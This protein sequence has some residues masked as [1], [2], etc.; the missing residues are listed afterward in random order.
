MGRLSAAQHASI[1][2]ALL[3]AVVW[4]VAV[5]LF[6][7]LFE[8]PS[9]EAFKNLVISWGE[10]GVLAAILLMVL[11]S[12]LPFPAELVA[13]ANGM[14][15]GPLWG[16]VITWVGAM[17]GAMLAFALSRR[18]GRPFV[19]RMLTRR[20]W[21]LVDEW[22]TRHGAGSFFVSRF[23]P[24]IAFNLINYAAGLTR[25]SWWTFLWTTA[26]GILPMTVL[27]VLLGAGMHELPLWQWLLLIVGGLAL[28]LV[29]HWIGA[30]RARKIDRS[31]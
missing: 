10:W 15:F 28:W 14:C 13:L 12:F 8:D 9:P 31:A 3:V 7:G 2:A 23:I 6:I 19:D 5:V 29:A 18:F 26:I 4:G 22:L 16:T 21:S 27:M 11:H 25:L 30:R 17:L 24:V 20:S 1:R